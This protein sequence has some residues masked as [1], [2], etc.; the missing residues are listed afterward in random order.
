MNNVRTHANHAYQG[1]TLVE[2]LVVL[3]I[4]SVVIVTFLSVFSQGGRLLIETEKKSVAVSLA[5][6][7][8]ERIRNLAYEN[9]GISGGIPD[10]PINPDEIRQ[11]GSNRYHIITDVR[12]YD[13]P[14]DGELGGTPNDT[15]NVDQKIVTVKVLWGEEDVSQKVIL[16]SVFVPPGIESLSGAGTLSINV[17]DTSG[18]GVTG[19][20]V[21]ITNASEGVD[22]TTSTDSVGNILLPGA[23][24]SQQSYIISVNKSG[25]ESVVTYPPYP[26]TT[27]VPVDEH[28]SVLEG[29]LTNKVIHASQLAN[30]TIRTVDAQGVA[31]PSILFSLFGGRTLGTTTDGD[32]V[33]SYDSDLVS[34]AS[35]EVSI[36]DVSPGDY[37][38][39]L[40]EPDLSNYEMISIT[41][42][43]DTA[44]EQF[45]ANPGMDETY[46]ILL[47]ARADP[48][49]WLTVADNDTGAEL[50]GVEVR[51]ENTTLGVDE[52]QITNTYGQVFFSDIADILDGELYSL[53]LTFSGYEDE[54]QSVTVSGLTIVDIPMVSL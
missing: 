51:I 40:R 1:F 34:N 46:E 37:F 25:Y 19:A 54:V 53:T 17:I 52:M 12:Y 47:A 14:F 45:S 21:N 50:S 35:G 49:I 48:G 28:A 30:I 13:H 31:L 26:T 20:T 22:L 4:V 44:R 29:D 11:I 39:A 41:P 32:D 5:N 15:V 3:F 36:D 16:S 8:M 7:Q 23:P 18:S 9:V 42:G 2:A 43:A 6:E 24:E 33:F 10:G 38:F 27:F